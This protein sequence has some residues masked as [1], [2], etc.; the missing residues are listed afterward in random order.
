MNV[1]CPTETTLPRRSARRGTPCRNVEPSPTTTN[2]SHC[3]SDISHGKYRN[4][5]ADTA[6]PASRTPARHGRSDASA[7]EEQ[8]ERL[9]RASGKLTGKVAVITGGDSGIGRAVA[10]MF[11][12]EGADVVIAYL[13]ERDDADETQRMVEAVG[14]VAC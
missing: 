2:I 8:S 7:A 5:D 12:K 14:R 4:L 10:V 1:Y 9:S 13:N 11:A 6:T 3:P